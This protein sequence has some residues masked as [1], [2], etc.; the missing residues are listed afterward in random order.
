M[1]ISVIC[2]W[3][4]T[5]PLPRKLM[6]FASD[7]KLVCLT[8]CYYGK[9]M[10]EGQLGKYTDC[11]QTICVTETSQGQ[12]WFPRYIHAAWAVSLFPLVSYSEIYTE[13]TVQCDVTWTLKSLGEVSIYFKSGLEN[14]W[15]TGHETWGLPSDGRVSV[16][17]LFDSDFVMK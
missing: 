1:A 9:R 4:A 8:T 5:G 6:S 16:G 15:T 10:T 12:D 13:S 11:H 3:Y 17:G 7:G 2:G 14:S